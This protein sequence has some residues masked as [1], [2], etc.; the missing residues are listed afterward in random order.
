M[1]TFH[2]RLIP[3]FL[4]L[5]ILL[6]EADG[7]RPAGEYK[8]DNPSVLFLGT[9][10]PNTAHP[11][12]HLVRYVLLPRNAAL[13]ILAAPDHDWDSPEVV[14]YGANTEKNSLLLRWKNSVSVDRG[15]VFL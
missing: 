11:Q 13:A 3:A 12:S 1:S 7:S 15:S 2:I 5:L 6:G 9:N 4:L 10:R 14:S 8:F